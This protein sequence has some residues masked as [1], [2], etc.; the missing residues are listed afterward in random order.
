VCPALTFP[1]IDR[2][3]FYLFNL[4]PDVNREDATV[5]TSSFANELRWMPAGLAKGCW[6]RPARAGKVA[7]VPRAP[8]LSR[9]GEKDAVWHCS[10]KNVHLPPHEE[11]RAPSR[12]SAAFW[13]PGRIVSRSRPPT[14]GCWRWQQFP[15]AALVSTRVGPD[16]FVVTPCLV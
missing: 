16:P 9:T 10:L 15:R 4:L 2:S 1:K 3:Y 13:Q 11:D 12:F 6:A 14:A 5:L 8:W 7:C